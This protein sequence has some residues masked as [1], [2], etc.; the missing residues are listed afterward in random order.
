MQRSMG[1]SSLLSCV[2]SSKSSAHWLCF[3]QVAAWLQHAANMLLTRSKLLV[4][5]MDLRLR[6]QMLAV[7]M[8]ETQHRWTKPGITNPEAN[9]A[10]AFPAFLK[11]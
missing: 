3:C 10:G 11:T 2:I 9:Q 7:R 6:C 1:L 4:L 5:H 8:I